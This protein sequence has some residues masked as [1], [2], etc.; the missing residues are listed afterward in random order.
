MLR[1]NRGVEMTPGLM[2][3][4]ALMEL[5]MKH[6][7]GGIA[8]GIAFG[9]ASGLLLGSCVFEGGPNHGVMAGAPAFESR[10]GQLE[11]GGP[12]GGGAAPAG[13]DPGSG[14]A[15]EAVFAKIASLKKA[16]ET[17]PNDRGSLIDLANLYYDAGKYE[18]AAGYYERAAAIDRNDPNLLTDLANCYM[19]Q[20]DNPRASS[21][22]REV[23]SK[24]PT[25]WQSAVNLFFVAE[26]LGDPALA[27]QALD[28]VKKLNPGFEKLPEME[29]RYEAM[30]RGGRS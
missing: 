1:A 24:F 30:G 22:L 21:L 18:Q 27:G 20:G 25:H 23:Q 26:I 28:A 3:A 19:F 14:A 17:N 12:M 11:G 29:K 7:F 16:V 15:M 9:V 13:M 6:L 10:G 2:Y 5:Q 8:G 4:S